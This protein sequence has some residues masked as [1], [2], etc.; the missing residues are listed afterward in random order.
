[1]SN[2][3]LKQI[4][5]LVAQGINAQAQDGDTA[6]MIASRNG[7]LGVVRA[8]IDEGANLDTQN[9]NGKTALMIAIFHNHSEIALTLID[10]GANLD[11]QDDVGDTALTIAERNGRSEVVQTLEQRQLIDFIRSRPSQ[12]PAAPSGPKVG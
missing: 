4:Y 10:K 5:N 3:T 1:M 8:L 11:A 12:R 2:D 6:L 7:R 9:I